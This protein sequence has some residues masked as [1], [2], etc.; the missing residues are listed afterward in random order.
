LVLLNFLCTSILRQLL[1]YTSVLSKSA[2]VCNIWSS[3]QYFRPSH[4]AP[5]KIAIII[6]LLAFEL[7]IVVYI[8][9]FIYLKSQCSII[10]DFFSYK[11][12]TFCFEYFK[13]CFLFS[14]VWQPIE[15]LSPFI[16]DMFLACYQPIYWHSKIIS[17]VSSVYVSGCYN[18]MTMV[19]GEHL[20]FHFKYR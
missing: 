11:F 20:I 9:H 15:E 18:I 3:L 10:F 12:F 6:F 5:G 1:R 19:L 7:H 8:L 14:F 4:L 16:A 2:C 13:V 17:E